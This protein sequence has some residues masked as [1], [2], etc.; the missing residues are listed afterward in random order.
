L[1]Y[2]SV[3]VLVTVTMRGCIRVVVLKW[4]RLMLITR[5]TFGLATRQGSNP[6]K[7]RG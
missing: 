1:A 4:S 5:T 2:R 6:N 7:K 3:A